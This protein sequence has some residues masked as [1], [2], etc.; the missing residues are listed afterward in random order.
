MPQAIYGLSFEPAT[1]V[2][3]RRR[4]SGSATALVEMMRAPTDP[5]GVE[6]QG[7]AHH[8]CHAITSAGVPS[9]SI[10][11]LLMTDGEGSAHGGKARLRG[12]LGLRAVFVGVAAS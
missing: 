8:E 9:S 6:S 5:E 2:D 12:S 11:N 3:V 7:G 10:V 1:D 4:A